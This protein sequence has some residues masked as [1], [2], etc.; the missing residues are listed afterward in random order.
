MCHITQSSGTGKSRMVDEMSKLVFTIPCNLL[1]A[2]RY[3]PGVSLN[4]LV[5]RCTDSS[6]GRSYP[7]P[8]LVARLF[9][10]IE[11][12]HL[13]AWYYIWYLTLLFQ[14]V[15]DELDV[16][17]E[18]KY[19]TKAD[20]ARAWHSHLLH[21]DGEAREAFTTE[22]STALTVPMKAGIGRGWRWKK[23]RRRTTG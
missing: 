14:A 13:S 7:P 4:L 23:C 18:S 21:D 12:K 1:S 8:D 19:R 11:S 15:L 9:D 20:F 6:I 10:T 17:G 16:M 22:S 5:P 3:T 2:K